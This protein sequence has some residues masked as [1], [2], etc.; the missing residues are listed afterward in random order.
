MGRK[1]KFIPEE[2][3]KVVET[4]LNGIDLAC[5]QARLRGIDRKSIQ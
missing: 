4:I 2:K 3:L 5:N 1:R